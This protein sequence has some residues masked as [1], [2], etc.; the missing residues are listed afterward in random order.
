MN[1]L[2]FMG[3]CKDWSRYIFNP[4]MNVADFFEMIEGKQYYGDLHSLYS[5]LWPFAQNFSL[6]SCISIDMF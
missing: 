6:G 2:Q 3:K 4:K 5:L 1:L